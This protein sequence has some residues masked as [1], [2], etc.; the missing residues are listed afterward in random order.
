MQGPGKSIQQSCLLSSEQPLGIL[1]RNFTHLLPVYTYVDR[2][3][4]I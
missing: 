1:K 2:P 3:S 4:G